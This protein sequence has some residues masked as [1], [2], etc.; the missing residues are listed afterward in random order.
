MLIQKLNLPFYFGGTEPT[1]SSWCCF[2]YRTTDPV[3]PLTAK[4]EGL[5]GGG[6]RA[7]LEGKI[8]N[9]II[10]RL[11]QVKAHNLHFS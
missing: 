5:I 7:A 9:L 6:K 1:H 10:L 11:A 4:Y 3:P 8:L 2:R